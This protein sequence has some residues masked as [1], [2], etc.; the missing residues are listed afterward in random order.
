MPHALALHIIIHE[1]FESDK[2]SINSIINFKLFGYTPIEMDIVSKI[3]STMYCHFIFPLNAPLN[4]VGTANVLSGLSFCCE[5]YT[6]HSL[7][8][9][10]CH[11]QIHVA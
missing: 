5:Y 11:I 4:C 3:H 8:I 1:R 7:R 2:P 10:M 9:L 6:D